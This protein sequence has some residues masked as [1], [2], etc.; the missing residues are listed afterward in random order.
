MVAMMIM[1]VGVM[2]VM[3]MVVVMIV[4][5][6]CFCHLTFVFTFWLHRK[7]FSQNTQTFH[8][9]TNDDDDDDDDD[10]DNDDD[11]ESKWL[12]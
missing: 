3:M 8:I 11:D 9:L 10:G 7:D 2:M 4:V 5:K 1:M 6:G 12:F